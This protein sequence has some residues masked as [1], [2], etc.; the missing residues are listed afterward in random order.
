[1]VVKIKKKQKNVCHK[2]Y[3]CED[4]KH[5]FRSNLILKKQPN[6]IKSSANNKPKKKKLWEK[7]D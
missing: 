3:K 4:Y 1:M 2:K 6:N 5:F 7:I